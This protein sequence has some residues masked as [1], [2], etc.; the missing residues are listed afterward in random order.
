MAIILEKEKKLK[1]AI[2]KS[3]LPEHIDVNLVN[4]ILIEI[5]KKYYGKN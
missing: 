4:D 2:E 5:R 1:E 3:T